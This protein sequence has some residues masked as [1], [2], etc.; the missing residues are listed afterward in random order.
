MNYTEPHMFVSVVLLSGH[1]RMVSHIFSNFSNGDYAYN[2][3]SKSISSSTD[4]WFP[5]QYKFM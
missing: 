4:T 5:I 1:V 2:S 3:V